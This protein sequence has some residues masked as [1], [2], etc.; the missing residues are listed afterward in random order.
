[1]AFY[2]PNGRYWLDGRVPCR[3]CHKN[4]NNNVFE[5]KPKEK[6]P[7]WTPHFRYPAACS[8]ARRLLILSDLAKDGIFE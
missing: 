2:A 5:Y 7:L 8:Q 4:F 1:M 6:A 3:V